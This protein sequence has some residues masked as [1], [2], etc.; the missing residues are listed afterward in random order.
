M[1]SLPIFT[2]G[3][4]ERSAGETLIKSEIYEC[5]KLGGPSYEV[6]LHLYPQYTYVWP[7]VQSNVSPD[8]CSA[9]KA[10]VEEVGNKRVCSDVL[11]TLAFLVL[12][13]PRECKCPESVA[14]VRIQNNLPDDFLRLSEPWAWTCNP[15]MHI[16]IS[17]SNMESLD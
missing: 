6:A 1:T 2:T 15:S 7:S 4:S 3:S 5:R 16:R 13:L 14:E 9:W 8:Y 17:E 11:H 12:P 10:E